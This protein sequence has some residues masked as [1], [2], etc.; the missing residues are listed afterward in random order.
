M[1]KKRYRRKAIILVAFP[2]IEAGYE[3]ALFDFEKIDKFNQKVIFGKK[4]VHYI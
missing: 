1:V 2:F 4:S 3:I